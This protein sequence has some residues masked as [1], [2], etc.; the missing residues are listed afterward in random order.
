MRMKKLIF[1]SFIFSLI[2]SLLLQPKATPQYQE[3]KVDVG[4]VLD[5]SIY[6][7]PDLSRSVTVLQD[8]SISFPLI[9]RIE[10]AGKSISEISDLIKNLLEKDYLYNP[11]VTVIIKEYRSK[12]V[13]ILGKVQ[14][15]GIYYLKGATTLLD[16]ISE[17]GILNP[18]SL[19]GKIIIHHHTTPGQESNNANKEITTIDLIELLVK[20]NTELNVYLKNGDN[21]YIPEANQFFIL[22]EVKKPG[23]YSLTNNLTVLK[24]ISIAGGLT[25]YANSKKISILRTETENK[26]KIYVNLDDIIKKGTKTSDPLLQADDVVVVPKRFF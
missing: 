2:T 20:G 10:V 23:F 6:A 25:E 11:H 16:I 5:I 21:I 26:Q 13:S 9:G 7:Q 15:P 8:G 18:A 19:G 14:K 12:K 3:Y 17:A 4:D 22:G 1:I 24:A